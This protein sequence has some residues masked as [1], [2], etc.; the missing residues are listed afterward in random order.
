MT[1]REI[2][3]AAL[4]KSDP[5]E[6]AAFL[7]QAC[8]NDRALRERVAQLLQK[9][10]LAGSFLEAPAP[11]LP[12]TL[13]LLTES[14]GTLIGPYK[15][16]EKL[17]EGGMG[18]VWIAER[19]N[20]KQRV[21]LK[22][23]KSGM[24]SK[25]IIRR[26]DAERQALALMSHNNIAK[27]LD[28]GTTESGRPYFVME[29]V[30][31]V[32]ITRYCDETHA[33]VQERLNLFIPVCL[34]VQHAHQKGI[35]HRDI[36]P[37]N[38]L[39][40]IEDGKP[41]PKVIDFGVAKALH[42]PLTEGTLHTAFN[43]IVGTLEYMSPEQAE[44]NALDIDTRADIYALGVLLFELLTGSTPI[45]RDELKQVAVIG[46]LRK[47]KEI[48]PRKPSTRLS[49]S[50]E[51][52]AS[53]AALRRT[54]PTK[55]MKEVRGDLDWIVLK[56]LE[57]D[58]T[59]RY[60]TANA[61]AREIERH[62]ANESVE[63]RPPTVGYRVSKFIRR[64]KSPVLAA[65][66]V[67]IA[68]IAGVIGTTWQMLRANELRGI[69]DEKTQRAL[70]AAESEKKAK[71]TAE[72]RETETKAVLDFVEN[73]IFA[74]ARPKDVERG[75]GYDV[76]LA[77]AIKA[78]LPFVEKG[79]ADQPLIEARLRHTLGTSFQFMGEFKNAIAQDEIARM[80]YA[81]Q[82]GASHRLTLQTMRNLALE[83]AGLGQLNVA[84]KINLEVLA[85][86]KESLGPYDPTTLRSMDQVA[87]TQNHLGQLNDAIKLHE[88]TLGLMKEKLGP[89]NPD[90]LGCMV[91]LAGDYYG[92]GR[93]QDALRLQESALAIMRIKIPDHRLTLFC[94][95]NLAISY[96]AQSRHDESLKIRKELVE[97]AKVKYGPEHPQTLTW[98]LNLASEYHAQGRTKE[99]IEIQEYT[100]P[101]FKEKL[102]NEHRVTLMNITNLATCYGVVNQ[103]REAAKLNTEAWEIQKKK[104]GVD[105]PSTLWTM[106]NVA[107]NSFRL[108]QVKEALDLFEETLRLRKSKLGAEHVETLKSMIH[109]SIAYESVGRKK[110]ALD[111]L[112]EALP[113][114]RKKYP[115]HGTTYHC[116]NKLA[117]T[118]LTR[119]QYG[120]AVPLYEELLPIRKAKL[121]ADHPD[122]LTTQH[123]L[124]KAYSDMGRYKE[125]LK[126]NQ[127]TLLLRKAKL[128][129][130][131]PDTLTTQHNLAKTY[132]DLGRYR[133][134][135]KLYQE[136]LPLQKA[137]LGPDHADTLRTMHSLSVTYFSLGQYAEAIS[138]LREALPLSRAKLGNTHGDTLNAMNTL[139]N[140]EKE[141]G[142]VSE[143]IKI[144]EETL[145]LMKDN[146]GADD[147]LTLGCM[148]NLAI[149]YQEA[150]RLKEAI[151]L[152]QSALASLK[153]KAPDDQFTF[154]AMTNL[155]ACYA[156]AGRYAEAFPLYEQSLA[157]R[158][159]KLG[160]DHPATLGSM[161]RLAWPLATC[162]DVKYRNPARALELARKAIN[163]PANQ[164]FIYGTLGA[165][166]YR[167]GAWNDAI[168]AL[169]KALQIN[170]EGIGTEG[171]FLAMA[172]WQLGQKEEARKWYD[173]AAKW[174]DKNKPKD[175]ELRRYRTEATELMN[176]KEVSIG[177]K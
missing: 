112:E 120:K 44:L 68:L 139:G 50:K 77:D 61:L 20:P 151:Q 99:A 25:Q 173:Q 82:L 22:L 146:F 47:I 46:M 170:P 2:F 166:N 134:A 76:K 67:L 9:N 38:V 58:R 148:V 69:A 97:I 42:Q 111:L 162:S 73:Y 90:T 92:S 171:F 5:A 135:V 8:A 117:D 7:D 19:D 10:E 153:G 41:V 115:S 136:A 81:K 147:V 98:M 103:F 128:G 35:I 30:K 79:F 59:R 39:V 74:A 175:E 57:S 161:L 158:T 15:L 100:L 31:G 54:E 144:H 142:H 48:E 63:A 109:L 14:P 80:I 13:A 37:S 143:A 78:A 1:E 95:N 87:T 138:L 53:L 21:A 125:A 6:R 16:L 83:Y 3:I 28:A 32:P 137:K 106:D 12:D 70:D 131:H 119:G 127:E 167:T 43:Q 108:G 116:M 164:D 168:T 157:L 160:P 26:F 145:K 91:N 65:A 88:E 154:N 33:S 124:A 174:M 24:D 62:L 121:G 126:L 150:K 149:D 17:S 130:D 172:Y 51:T 123:N 102:G 177:P 105:H 27:M 141:L 49:E 36:K 113:I 29:L 140:C 110:D 55:L 40:C 18:T 107:Q 176:D 101:L 34:A 89:D 155:A 104:F 52:I 165:A 114:L 86:A 72:A 94:M 84:Q 156:E 56:C 64:N 85:R 23:I 11:G 96:S 71:L 132:D 129:A 152:N 4:Q 118:Y 122:T 60:E 159:S 169:T 75:Q 93:I 45:T 66:L 133:E 163:Y